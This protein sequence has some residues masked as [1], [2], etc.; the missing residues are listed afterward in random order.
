MKLEWSNYRTF[1]EWV[2]VEDEG[3]F[4]LAQVK[5]YQG[6]W[7]LSWRPH[8]GKSPGWSDSYWPESAL[9]EAKAWAV[10]MIRMHQ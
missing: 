1:M 4:V 5:R 2:C 9:E 10:A 8:I 3:H 7:K 6:G